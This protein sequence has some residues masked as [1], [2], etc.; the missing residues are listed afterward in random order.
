MKK[1]FIASSLA[2]LSVSCVSKKKLTQAENK[3]ELRDAEITKLREEN[4]LCQRKEESL[5]E[6][7]MLYQAQIEKLQDQNENTLRLSQ[8]GS[9]ENQNTR[10]KI[11]R[12]LSGVDNDRLAEAKNFQDSLNIAF[13]ENIKKSL[14]DKLDKDSQLPQNL[15]VRVHQPFVEISIGESI[16]FNSGSAFVNP[17]AYKIL[18]HIAKVLEA[19]SPIMIRVEGHTDQQ[20]VTPNN[21]IKDN[22]ELSLKRSAAVIRIFEDK[23]NIDGSRMIA[24]GRGEF[25]PISDN[26]TADGRQQNRRTEIRLAPDL[27]TFMEILNK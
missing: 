6:D 4:E 10:N 15:N 20:A 27:K 12:I 25:D 7:L 19:E 21:Y 5:E 17:K 3:L 2:I 26:S 23:F 13:E 8:N 1:L 14:I 9:L 24:S 18:G 11:K 22:W 16:L